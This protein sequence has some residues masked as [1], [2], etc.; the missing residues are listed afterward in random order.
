[1]RFIRR[2]VKAVTVAAVVSVFLLLSQSG[3]SPSLV[4]QEEEPVIFGVI[5]VGQGLSQIL[6]QG[7]R[8]ILFDAGTE[9]PA[10]C[11]TAAYRRLGSPRLE[12]VVISHRDLDH[13]GGL[14]FL[15]ETVDWS[16]RLIAGKWEDTAFIRSCCS[17]WNGPV[18]VSTIAQDD[19]IYFT[20]NCSIDCRWPAASAPDSVPVTDE[21]TND[22]SLVLS[23][24]FRNAGIL[25]T[26]DIDS[27]T[28]KLV[29]RKY[30]AALRADIVVVPHHGSAS[31]N[32]PLLYGYSRPNVAIISVG[33]DNTYGHPAPST[34]DLLADLGIVC[35]ATDVEGSIY[36]RTSGYYWENGK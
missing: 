8:A 30:Q 21:T 35:R 9:D 20:D 15:D 6:M 7:N 26:G 18:T 5:D 14:R 17:K 13:A 31:S 24:L 12:A 19:S 10:R 1:M 2:K 28:A 11:W 33:E 4:A 3:C 32:C 27:T 23:I 29:T 34:T 36:L 16:G 25:L 22:Y